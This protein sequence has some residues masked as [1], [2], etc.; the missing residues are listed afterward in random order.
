MGNLSTNKRFDVR[1]KRWFNDPLNMNLATE[2]G[3]ELHG[4][5]PFIDRGTICILTSQKSVWRCGAVSTLISLCE[6][7]GFGISQKNFFLHI[8]C[9]TLFFSSMVSAD[10]FGGFAKPCKEDTWLTRS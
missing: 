2:N 5:R 3:I 6:N 7:Q 9:S 10:L 4:A 8:I 1:N